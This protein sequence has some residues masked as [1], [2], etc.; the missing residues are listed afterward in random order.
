VTGPSAEQVLVLND[1][2]HVQGGASKVAIDEAIALAEAGVQITFLGA[3]GPICEALRDAPLRVVCLEQPQLLD[4]ARRPAAALQG[5]LNRAANAAM[6]ELLAPLDPKSTIIHLHGYTK[7][8]TTGPALV[9]RRAGFR[10]VVT[11]HDFFSACPNGA[12]YDYRKQKPCSLVALSPACIV[13]ACDKRHQVHKAYRVVRG[14]AQRHLGR[15]PSCVRDYVTLSRRSADLLRPYLP[16]DAALYPLDNIIDV[17]FAPPVNVAANRSL[18]VLGR[19]DEEKGVTLAAE[20]ASRAGWPIVFAGEGPERPIL[21]R[22]GAAITG[23]VSKEHVWLLLEQARCLIFPSRWYETFGLVVSEAAA[24]GIPAVVSGVSA[25]AE[26]INEGVTG[27]TFRSGDADDLARCLNLLCDDATVSRV[28]R[29]AYDEFW[30]SP[31][32]R[33]HHTEALLSIYA[34]VLARCPGRSLRTCTNVTD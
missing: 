3:V 2:C 11:L 25:A 31:P 9:A 6:R 15:F 12:F 27:W 34:N 32:D 1:F 23:W 29:A 13:T 5:I 20:T 18:L 24:R 14:L 17:P 7:A 30:S 19:L 22:L 21:E 8:L 16:D 26:R 33:Q 4:V 28:G 10:P